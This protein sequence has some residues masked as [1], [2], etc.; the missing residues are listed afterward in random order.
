MYAPRDQNTEKEW[1]YGGEKK[2]E[3]GDASRSTESPCHKRDTRR[4]GQESRPDPEIPFSFSRR[5]AKIQRSALV[6]SAKRGAIQ[7]RLITSKTVIGP[8]KAWV[9]VAT[10]RD[11]FPKFRHAVTH[12]ARQNRI[13]FDVST[14]L[15][16]EEI[17][18]KKDFRFPRKKIG[19]ET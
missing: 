4:G 10:W 8:L 16:E 7:P 14:R 17:S 6:F 1:R 11:G 19:K 13:F 18:R 15:G 2:K 12:S 5:S 9:N 3:I